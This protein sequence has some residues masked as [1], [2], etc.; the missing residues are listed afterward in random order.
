MKL[1]LNENDIY[2][3]QEYLMK[4]QNKKIYEIYHEIR[5]KKLKERTKEEHLVFTYLSLNKRKLG[6]K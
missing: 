2:K 1:K 5:L 3:V 4:N 6:I